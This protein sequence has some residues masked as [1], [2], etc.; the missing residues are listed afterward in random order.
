MKQGY[1]SNVPF[2]EN[3]KLKIKIYITLLSFLIKILVL[4]AMIFSDSP[5]DK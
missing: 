1:T 4:K 3:Q 5:K 2:W